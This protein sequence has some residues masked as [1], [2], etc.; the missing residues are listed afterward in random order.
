R[1][2]MGK[3]ACVLV[4]GAL[5]AAG[6]GSSSRK[7]DSSSGTSTTA[8]G[9]TASTKFGDLDSPCGKGTAKGATDQGVTDTAI[10]VEYGDDAGFTASPG[11]NKEMGDAMKGMLKW[12]NDQ[13]GILGRQV[14]GVYGDAAITAVN[15]KMQEACKTAFMLVGTGWALDGASEATR[16]QCGLPAVPG[17]AVSPEYAN[18]PMM[19]QAVPNPADQTP[20]SNVYEAAQ[21]WPDKIKKADIVHSTLVSATET[22]SAKVRQAGDQAGFHWLDCGVTLNYNGEAD[23]KPFAQKFQSCGA[24]ILFLNLSPGP[25]VYGL[26][27]AMDQLNY[28]PIILGEANLYSPQMS[29]WN[30]AGLADNLY[31]REAF[32]PLEN[33]DLIPAVKT[34]LDAVKATGGD[35]SQLGEQTASSFLLWAT[36]AKGC[37]STLT[38]QCMINGLAKV[39]KWT[40]GGLHSPADPGANTP[41]TCGLLI[42]LTKTT[43]A[44]SF[45][46]K[47]GTLDCNDKYGVKLSGAA[48]STALGPDR[49]ATKFLTGKELKPQG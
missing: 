41:P 25:V 37:G 9:S 38:R 42:K 33:A 17:F 7:S 10:T 48:I 29:K 23:Y 32:Q 36:V 1:R 4:L 30:T 47:R 45:P 26:I 20:A 35:A 27:Q 12:C 19:Y 3:L 46:T 40:G 43:Y 2:S 8:A 13:G 11:L 44:Q 34:Y 22:S 14:T 6:C 15:T 18:G 24:E 39:H 28:H 16:L 21:L 49:I 31:V 5:V